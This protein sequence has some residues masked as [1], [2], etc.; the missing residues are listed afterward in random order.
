MLVC[1]APCSCRD[2]VCSELLLILLLVPAAG[3][4]HLSHLSTLHMQN[5]RTLGAY[6]CSA[7]LAKVAAAP[8]LRM[9][10]LNL[11]VMEN[12]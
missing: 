3:M 6:A 5:T 7:L 1:F 11:S 10:N 4:S 8:A 12:G 9:L 2:Q